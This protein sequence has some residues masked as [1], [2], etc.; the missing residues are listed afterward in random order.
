[1]IVVIGGLGLVDVASRPESMA[2]DRLA[3]LMG[4]RRA[5]HQEARPDLSSGILARPAAI[6]LG[7]PSFWTRLVPNAENLNLLYEQADVSFSFKTLPGDRRR[8]CR[9]RSGLRPGVSTAVLRRA[10]GRGLFLGSLPFFWLITPQAE[11]DPPV[12]RR[13]CP[14]RSS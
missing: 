4:G 2:E 5:R 6:D 13:R 9:G 10:A 3:G 1:M 8:A 12:R 7:R 11:A 14:R